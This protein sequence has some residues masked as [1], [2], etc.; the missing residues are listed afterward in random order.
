MVKEVPQKT[1]RNRLP[2]MES[3]VREF[4]GNRSRAQ[5]PPPMRGTA[6]NLTGHSPPCNKAKP[7]TCFTCHRTGHYAR[8]CRESK[9]ANI[10]RKNVQGNEQQ[11]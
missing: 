5:C 7:V 2:I 9:W 10:R 6:C 1:S 4:K 3:D 11:V 8:D